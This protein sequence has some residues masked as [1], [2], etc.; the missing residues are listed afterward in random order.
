MIKAI[1]CGGPFPDPACLQGDEHWMA[2]ALREG[3]KGVGLS[4]P[5]PPVGCALVRDGRL[6]GIGVHTKAGEAHGEIVA[7]RDAQARGE[8]TVGA[9]AY[10]TLEPC[11]HHGRT[12]PCT[13]ALMKAGITRIVAGVRDPNPRV[14]GGGLALLRQHGLDVLEGVLEDSCRCFHA[15]FFK[16]IRTGLP[17]VALKLALGSDDSLGPEGQNTQVTPPEVQ[18]CAHLLRRISDAILV[19][20]RTVEVDDPML[21][22]R[23]PEEVPAHRIFRRI[24]LDSQGRLSPKCR[25]WGD[26][27]GQPPMRATLGL[28]ES[29]PGVQ[30]ISLPPGSKGCSLHH[31]LHELSAM[32]VSRLLVEGGGTLVRHFLDEDLVDEFHIFRAECPAGG[33]PLHLP[34]NEGWKERASVD[35]KDAV[36]C[37]LEHCR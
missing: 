5:N 12:P 15:P 1:A 20:R 23:W 30:D 11:C 3:L 9:T 33:E 6:I 29:I 37:A 25:L 21:T 35:F 31:L 10:V 24:A 4:S 18:Q 26:V 34:L 13:D 22:D 16:Q 32:G 19:G 14:D 8:N 17:W 27:P 28:R 36:W 2:L 7:L